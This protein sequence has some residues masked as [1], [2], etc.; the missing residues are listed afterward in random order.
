MN[1]VNSIETISKA[2][3]VIEKVAKYSFIAILT[4]GIASCFIAA[5]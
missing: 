5:V 2:E 4:V 3:A 1:N